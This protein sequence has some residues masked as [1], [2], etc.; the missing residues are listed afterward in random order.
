MKII[1]SKT[2]NKKQKAE[3][4]KL[5]NQEYPKA[6]SL[7]GL[8]AFEDYLRHL[9]DKHHLLLTDE[10]DI[11]MGW[12][13]YFIRDDERCFAMILHASLQGRGYGSRLLNLA[14]TYNP[15]LTGW[16]IDNDHQQMESREYYK[17]PVG[18]YR[19]NDFEILSDIQ[20]RKKNIN[21]VKVRWRK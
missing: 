4:L 2:L 6:L 10:A 17:S 16:V 7:S 9:S 13:I 3:I 21:G 12:L 14:K 15:E 8:T 19:K 5:W 11:V 18:F 1:E 20:S